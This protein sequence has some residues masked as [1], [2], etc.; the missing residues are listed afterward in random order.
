MWCENLVLTFTR[1]FSN[2]RPDIPTIRTLQDGNAL[3][4]RQRNSKSFKAIECSTKI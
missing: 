1:S 2:K 4:N 3:D